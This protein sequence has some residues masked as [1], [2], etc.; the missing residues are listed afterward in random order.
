MAIWIVFN[1]I[2]YIINL[3]RLLLKLENQDIN[4]DVKLKSIEILKKDLSLELY[5]IRSKIEIL[6]SNLEKLESKLKTLSLERESI[7]SKMESFGL[8][9]EI[10]MGII[11]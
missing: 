7:E 10:E 1:F 5:K 8:K 11:R 2:T 4:E 3:I 6:K 9:D